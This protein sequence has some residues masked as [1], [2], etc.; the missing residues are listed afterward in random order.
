MTLTLDSCL[1][2]SSAQVIRVYVFAALLFSAS[3]I[4]LIWRPPPQFLGTNN[5]CSA[6]EPTPWV[7]SSV[8]G[9][10][11]YGGGGVVK[12]LLCPKAGFDSENPLEIGK[13]PFDLY[14][15]RTPPPPPRRPLEGDGGG[16]G[17][18]RGNDTSGSTG[19]S[20]RQNAATRRNMRREERV[21]VQGLVKA[22]QP[23]G[24]SHGGGGCRTAPPP[25]P[26]K[27]TVP[28]PA[29]GALQG[30]S[31]GLPLRQ[32]KDAKWGTS[33]PT[34]AAPCGRVRT[35]AAV[36]P[37][38]AGAMGHRHVAWPPGA[39]A[40]TTVPRALRIWRVP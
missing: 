37:G 6:V 15:V 21:T 5:T 1:G 26:P 39:Q 2:N 4:S 29:L 32:Q 13:V 35:T 24:M 10:L 36:P 18:E 23:D 22:Q 7:L 14:W 40:R 9:G 27:C 16:G 12:G 34:W 17:S 25:R 31:G 8:G 3:L 33:P 19:R 28:L 11:G 30:L 38:R 20:G